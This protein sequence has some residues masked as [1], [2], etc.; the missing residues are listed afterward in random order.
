[1]TGGH[2]G[3]YDL[4]GNNVNK[5][6][7]KNCTQHNFWVKFDENLTITPSKEGEP[8]ATTSLTY[9]TVNGVKYYSGWSTYKYVKTK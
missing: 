7:F 8:G 4:T 3:T 5:I 9:K 1:M 2:L 6:V